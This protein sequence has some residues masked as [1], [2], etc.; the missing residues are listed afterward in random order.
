MLA[1]QILQITSDADLIRR[2][3]HESKV[4]Y[5]HGDDTVR[6]ILKPEQNTL[7]LRDIPS[8]T[9]S[10]DIV[11]IFS[12]AAGAEVAFTPAGIRADMNDTWC[13]RRLTA[14]CAGLL[15]LCSV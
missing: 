5:V 4:I 14:L 7:I 11:G 3:L 2:A 8:S 9:P 15:S 13:V 1:P 6:A 12:R 10:D